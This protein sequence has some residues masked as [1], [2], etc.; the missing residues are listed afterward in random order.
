MSVNLRGAPARF[1]VVIDGVPE[2]PMRPGSARFV[3]QG[4][5]SFSYT[6]VGNV[7]AFENDDTH[8]FDVQWR[9]PS[10]RKVTLTRGDLNLLFEQGRRN[11]P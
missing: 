1:R 10:G 4:E 3:P 6:F 9:S 2:A 7:A 5:E 8:V 11:C